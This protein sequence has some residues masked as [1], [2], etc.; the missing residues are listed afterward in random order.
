MSRSLHLV[1]RALAAACV[2]TLA[3]AH[4]ASP[5]A[6]ASA[7][8]P[9]AGCWDRVPLL[10]QLAVDDAGRPGQ[11]IR[12]REFIKVSAAELRVRLKIFVPKAGC[13]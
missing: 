10:V 8:T 9:C 13:L 1:S 6:L 11:R 4:A 2:F 7:P 3:A 5:Q 12:D